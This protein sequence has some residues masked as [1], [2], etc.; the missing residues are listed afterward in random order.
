MEILEEYHPS[1][2]VKVY[3]VTNKEIVQ[4]KKTFAKNDASKKYPDLVLEIQEE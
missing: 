2:F 3:D 1:S 4:I